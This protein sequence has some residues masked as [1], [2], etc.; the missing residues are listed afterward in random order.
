MTTSITKKSFGKRYFLATIIII[1]LLETIFGYF[2][3][4]A[5]AYMVL[6]GLTVLWV[7]W[8]IWTLM[9][10]R[11]TEFAYLFGTLMLLFSAQNT[12]NHLH[13]PDWWL[14]ILVV[15]L[16]LLF[17]WGIWYAIRERRNTANKQTNA[18]E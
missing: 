1:A 13:F 7:L 10:D 4:P 2:A 16:V 5:W 6:L 11:Q 15:A 8:L 18:T 9:A 3:T 14:N 12:S 17:P